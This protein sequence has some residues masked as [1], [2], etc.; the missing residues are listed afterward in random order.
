M[1]SD[2]DNEIQEINNLIN[3]QSTKSWTVFYLSNNIHSLHTNFIYSVKKQRCKK[4]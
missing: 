2:E 1:E 3:T 4:T